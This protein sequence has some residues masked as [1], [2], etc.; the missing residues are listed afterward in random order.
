MSSIH[1]QNPSSSTPADR[2]MPVPLTQANLAAHN[3]QQNAV[4]GTPS[5]NVRGHD[6]RTM[7]RAAPAGVAAAS[8]HGTTAQSSRVSAWLSSTDDR[9]TWSLSGEGRR[10]VLDVVQ[11]GHT[12]GSNDRSD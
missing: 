1:K 5:G 9:L 6:D 11:S 3:A 8:E 10:R 12:D 4:G 2:T 7:P